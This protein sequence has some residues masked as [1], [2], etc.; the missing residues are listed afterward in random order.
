MTT[1]GRGARRWQAKPAAAAPASA[2]P[3]SAAVI[4]PWSDLPDVIMEAILDQ[5]TVHERA[6]IMLTN[7][8]WRDISVR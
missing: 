5:L 6:N 2:A 3:S 4:P 1:R 7:K 8:R